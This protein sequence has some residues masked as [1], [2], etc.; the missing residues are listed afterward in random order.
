MRRR[1]RK[2]E[3]ALGVGFLVGPMVYA[4]TLSAPEAQSCE[5]LP[6]P[7][8]VETGT[9]EEPPALVQVEPP[10]APA[11]KPESI[12]EPREFAFTQG[13]L[14]V[15][16]M[17][18]DR[19][20]GSGEL[21]EPSGEAE[22][23]AAKLAD[24]DRVPATQWAQ[25]GRRFDLYGRQGK[26]CSVTIDRL[27]IVAQYG[28]GL[29]GVLG[30]G[31]GWDDERNQPREHSPARIRR[32]VWRTQTPWLVGEVALASECEGALWARDAELPPPE[33]LRES[34]SESSV[35]KARVVELEASGEIEALR[36]EY[37]GFLA[38]LDDD[39]QRAMYGDWTARVRGHEAEVSAWIDPSGA[40]RFVQ[41]HFGID[42][43]S[44]GD[45]HNTEIARL[46]RV[47]G[48]GFVA[49]DMADDPDAIVDV[50][51]DGRFELL[52]GLDDWGQARLV[53]E[54]GSSVQL[55]SIEQDWMCP[56]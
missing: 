44:C 34:A 16:S 47:V 55:L 26:L 46:D 12:A 28:W 21:F 52:Y 36:A 15:L 54:D 33:L 4:L 43:A 6:I 7:V 23:R 19:R 49:T 9:W 48:S 27:L 40:T 2:V 51:L 56:C 8:V 24:P 22:H 38:E 45:G 18:A 50:D 53:A 3:L 14:I 35:T 42:D 13:N 32:A 30:P 10:P 29:E 11:P 25:Q 20:W 41:L 37:E 1:M 31:A 5:R 39:E 17:D